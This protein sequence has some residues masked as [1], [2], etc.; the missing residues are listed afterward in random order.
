MLFTLRIVTRKRTK[1]LSDTD[2]LIATGEPGRENLDTHH[3]KG[4]SLGVPDQFAIS[5]LDLSSVLETTK[6]PH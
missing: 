6:R 1:I 2:R 3:L 5:K 4:R